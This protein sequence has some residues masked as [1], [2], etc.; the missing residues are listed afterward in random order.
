MK[1][2]ADISKNTISSDLETMI[3][4]I[5]HLFTVYITVHDNMGLFRYM[6]G[7]ILLPDRNYHPCPYC[8][9]G[10]FTEP[11]WRKFCLE[12]CMKKSDRFA[13]SETV[14]FIK[15]CW[16]GVTELVVPIVRHKKPIITLYVG[17]FKGEIPAETKLSKKYLLMHEQLPESPNDDEMETL[18]RLIIMLGQGMLGALEYVIEPQFDLDSGRQHKISR[19]IQE[20]AHEK[21]QLDDLANHLYLSPSRTS[22]LVR[23]LFKKSFTALLIQ[24]RMLRAKSLLLNE[25]CAIEDIS[26]MVGFKNIY[27]FNSAFKK[28]FGIPPGRFRKQHLN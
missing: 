19:F 26:S 15:N 7:K 13:I 6:D 9:T 27:Y 17:G 1:V 2:L 21:I 20:H 12:D 25:W 28:F 11:H 18:K 23:S 16:K 14:P 10:R 5:E 3:R 8:E 4:E 24:E 22:H